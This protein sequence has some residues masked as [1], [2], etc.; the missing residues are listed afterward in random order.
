MLQASRDAQYGPEDRHLPTLP[1][2][3]GEDTG[4]PQAQLGNLYREGVIW[5]ET[6]E[7]SP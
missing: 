5:G 4:F 3:L 7:G 2:A 6:H 1:R